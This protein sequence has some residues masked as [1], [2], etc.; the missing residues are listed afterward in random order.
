MQAK[1]KKPEKPFSVYG[2]IESTDQHQLFIAD[3]HEQFLSNKLRQSGW[4]YFIG[5]IFCFA[6]GTVLIIKPFI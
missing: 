1:E 5:S 2:I 6:V 3:L 4:L